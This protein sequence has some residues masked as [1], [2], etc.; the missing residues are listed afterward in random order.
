M[1]DRARREV[2]KALCNAFFAAASL[3][4]LPC[5]GDERPS[6]EQ[7]CVWMRSAAQTG[8]LVFRAEDG[9]ISKMVMQVQ[10]DD[11]YSHVG[12]V[13]NHSG[14]PL[15]YHAEIDGESGAQG[16]VKQDLCFYLRR[17]ERAA[18][19]RPTAFAETERRAVADA[20][21]GLGYRSFNWRLLWNPQDGS[22]YCTQYVWQIFQMAS[23]RRTQGFSGGPVLTVAKLLD[24]M[25]LSL[26]R[27]WD[28]GALDQGM[29]RFGAAQ[30]ATTAVRIR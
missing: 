14:N 22:V 23:P 1:E 9:A 20:V 18:L 11:R 15:V 30:R 8:D 16:V 13:V 19:M 4:C 2:S 3:A 29:S 6:V 21:A 28:E 17:A 10:G 24:S 5:W 27:K 12:V 25:S 26:V 7:A